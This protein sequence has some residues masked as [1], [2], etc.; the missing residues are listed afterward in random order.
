MLDTGDDEEERGEP[1]EED[2][3]AVDPDALAF[4]NAKKKVDDLHK[5]KK[6]DKK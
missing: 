3:F 1:T 2:G 5:A 4:I 6:H